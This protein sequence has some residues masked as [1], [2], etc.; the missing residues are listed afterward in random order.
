MAGARAVR[1]LR[2]T[3]HTTHGMRGRQAWR[4]APFIVPAWPARPCSSTNRCVGFTSEDICRRKVRCARAKEAEAKNEALDALMVYL[5][6]YRGRAGAGR[7]RAE[8]R[9]EGQIRI[10][11]LHVRGIPET[12]CTRRPSP[13]LI[14][15]SWVVLSCC[16][17]QPRRPP[18]RCSLP[19]TGLL[20]LLSGSPPCAAQAGAPALRPSP[21]RARQPAYRARPVARAAGRRCKAV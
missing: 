13:P 14:R 3:A 21:P 7:A 2:H 1:R 10:A 16:R 5:G 6:P 8:S 20:A 4:E 11:C 12:L 19:S 18:V 17:L 9:F 15:L